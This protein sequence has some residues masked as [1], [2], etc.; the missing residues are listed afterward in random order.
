MD[1]NVEALKEVCKGVKMGM[2]A[3]HY[4]SDKVEDDDLKNYLHHE[5][6]MYNNILDKANDAFSNY[7]ANP[8]DINLGTKAMLWYG[9]QMNTLPD[10][11]TSKISELLIKGTTSGI[12][13]GKRILNQ[14]TNLDTD[15]KNLLVDFV[16]FQEESVE[17]L[18]TFL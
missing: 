15:V 1:K 16:N 4:V 7:D 11:S 14:N 9:I 8:R 3:I 5:Y 18:K 2:D 17:K 6:S 12:I 13:E 10:S